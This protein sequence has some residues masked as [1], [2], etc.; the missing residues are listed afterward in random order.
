LTPAVSAR[1]KTVPVRVGALVIGGPAPLLVQSMTTTTPDRINDSLAQIAALRAAGCPL[2]RLAVP[3]LAAAHALPAL[4]A[5][6]RERGLDLPLVADVH[7]DARIALVAAQHVEKVRINPGNFAADLATAR[8]RLVPL[9]EI[10]RARGAALRVGVNH[11]S[12]PAFVSETLG[13][14]PEAL[15]HLALAYLHLCRELDFDQ[16]VVSIK[17]SN[18][19]LMIAAN[20]RLAGLLAAEGLATPVHLGV[21]EAGLGREGALRSLVGIGPLLLD[22]IGDTIRVSLTGDP[23]TEIPVCHAILRAVAA[24]RETPRPFEEASDD[25]PRAGAGIPLVEIAVDETDLPHATDVTRTHPEANPGAHPGADPGARSD[26]PRDACLDLPPV[27]SVLLRPSG[28]D[29]APS[30]EG[31]AAD[32]H[33]AAPGRDL[34]ARIALHFARAGIP[35]AP[36]FALWIEAPWDARAAHPGDSARAALASEPGPQG[37]S[38]RIPAQR[39]AACLA[40]GAADGAL[41]SQTRA[42]ADFA[43]AAARAQPVPAARPRL[44]WHLEL[45]DSLV[46]TDADDADDADP[47][48]PRARLAALGTLAGHL[49][50]VAL[51]AGCEPAAFCVSGRPLRAASRALAAGMRGQAEI[52][53][54]LP[55]DHDEAAVTAGALLIEGLADAIV[56]DLAADPAA[57]APDAARRA[58]RFADALLQATRR[59]LTHAEFI[60]CPGCGRLRFDLTATVTRLKA[61]LAPFAGVK[62][63][64]MGCIVNGPGEMADADF[65]YVGSGEERVDLYAGRVCVRRALTPRAAEDALYA[66]VVERAAPA[67]GREPR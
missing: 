62:I 27:E 57:D 21:T 26:T 25:P 30:P 14:G 23:V 33:R 17:A 61:R 60:S 50:R 55:R 65:G 34:R 46:T 38:L 6:M 42:L 56:I 2:V 5:A 24:A 1:R 41:P 54:V 58:L 67:P 13:H 44:R 16:V 9:V 63:A 52:H 45:P 66:L 7:F 3:S 15:A 29:V 32:G 18:P 40:R 47:T 28:L 12:L 37:L 4:R 22:G 43:A 10:L 53:V 48:T 36:E 35:L 39:I 49:T 59:R 64:V 51:E 31:G 11:G 20:R 8:E 19:A